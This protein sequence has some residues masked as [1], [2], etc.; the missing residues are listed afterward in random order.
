MSE[1]KITK[2]ALFCIDAELQVI[3]DHCITYLTRKYTPEMQQIYRNSNWCIPEIH[4]VNAVEKGKYVITDV[5][6]I[7]VLISDWT[8]EEEAAELSKHRAKIDDLLRDY[9]LKTAG[10]LKLWGAVEDDLLYQWPIE[11]R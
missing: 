6:T 5:M 3:G 4:T 9:G 8:P 7:D 1:I 11:K 2:E 10:E